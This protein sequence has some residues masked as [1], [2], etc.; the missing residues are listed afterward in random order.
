MDNILE[1]GMSDTQRE[2]MSK[3]DAG[4]CEKESL[5]LDT[6]S[7]IICPFCEQGYFDKVGLKYH[8][9]SGCCEIFNEL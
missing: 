1:L 8:L 9:T 2:K 4:I 5:L 7:D 6:S 3:I